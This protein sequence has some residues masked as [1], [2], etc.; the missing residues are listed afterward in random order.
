M[1]KKVI[2]QKAAELGID[3]LGFSGARELDEV[4][5]CLVKRRDEGRQTSLEWQ[6]IELRVNPRL[7][8]PG[9]NTIITAAISYFTANHARTSGMCGTLSRSAWGTDYH[10]VLGSKLKALAQYIS[11]STGT[12]TKV[13]VDTGPPVDR[14]LAI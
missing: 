2:G 8:L 14:A 10:R 6:D 1:L 13:F 12:T 4:K 5:R 11:E 9:A 7:L 3:L